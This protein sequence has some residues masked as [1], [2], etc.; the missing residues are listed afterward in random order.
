MEANDEGVS[1]RYHLPYLAVTL[2]LAAAN[3]AQA[4]T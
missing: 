4:Y 2:A 1:S 3:A